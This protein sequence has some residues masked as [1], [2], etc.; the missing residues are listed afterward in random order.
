VKLNGVVIAS[1]PSY[2]SPRGSSGTIQSNK[3]KAFQPALRS[4]YPPKS[5]KPPPLFQEMTAKSKYSIHHRALSQSQG[6][7]SNLNP[8]NTPDKYQVVWMD[9]AEGPQH[10]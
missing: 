9:K 3:I 5:K 8:F 2:P 10:H 7:R 6:G 1:T 4:F